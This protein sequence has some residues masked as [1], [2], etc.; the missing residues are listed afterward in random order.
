MSILCLKI[1]NKWDSLAE[2]YF[3]SLLPVLAPSA[4]DTF[5][6]CWSPYLQC[7]MLFHIFQSSVV[8]FPQFLLIYKFSYLKKSVEKLLSQYFFSE[9]F[10]FSPPQTTLLDVP[11]LCIVPNRLFWA[12]LVTQIV[13]NLPVLQ[14]TWVRFPGQADPL[15]EG[16]ATHSSILVWRIPWTEE[17]GGLQSM[18]LQRVRHNWVTNTYSIIIISLHA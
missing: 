4:H 17:A 14:K 11:W 3:L 5:W 15:E 1:F 9:T 2:Q 7:A 6:L 8:Q 10:T 12:Y 16:M 18:W 13:K